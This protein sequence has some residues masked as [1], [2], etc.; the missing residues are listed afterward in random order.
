MAV[1]TRDAQQLHR[2]LEV[3]HDALPR[4]AHLVELRRATDDEQTTL[5]LRRRRLQ[6]GN[7]VNQVCRS[8]CKHIQLVGRLPAKVGSRPNDD[9][10]VIIRTLSIIK[11]LDDGI[12]RLRKSQELRSFGTMVQERDA[13]VGC[14]RSLGQDLC[15]VVRLFF[16]R[17]KSR[18]CVV[19]DVYRHGRFHVRW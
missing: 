13:I 2:D 12:N 17:S 18:R 11:T 6:H 1:T 7:L 3:V 16:S 10:N 19:E 9:A 4:R 15:E 14:D 5:K 8:R